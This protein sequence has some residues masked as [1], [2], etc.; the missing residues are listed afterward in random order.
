M[1]P[2]RHWSRRSLLLALPLLALAFVALVWASSLAFRGARVDLT[3]NRQYTLSPGTLRIL[4]KIP[5][6]ITLQLYYSE[7]AAQREPQFRIFAQRVREL[8][9]EVAAKSN[10]K[11]TLKVVDPEPFSD[12]EDK[13]TEYG[14]TAVPL[15]TSGDK[16]YFGLVGSNSTDGE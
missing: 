4:A 5:D 8:L 11:L 15:G 13:A 12:A 6:P 14:L 3:Q 10:G 7:E 9:E 16:L 1:R 2:M